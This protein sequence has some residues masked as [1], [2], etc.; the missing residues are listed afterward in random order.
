[1][2]KN[3]LFNL[4]EAENQLE[5]SN[6]GC[7]NVVY[8]KV[9]PTRLCTG[10]LFPNGSISFKFNVNGITWLNLSKS[11]FSMKTKLTKANGAQLV[12]ADNV[13]YSMNCAQNLFSSIELRCNS[14]T[15]EKV[16]DR[17]GETSTLQHREQRSQA[18]LNTIGQSN[19]WYPD[20]NDRIQLV[21]SDGTVAGTGFV[22]GGGSVDAENYAMISGLTETYSNVVSDYSSFS[23][24]SL[25]TSVLPVVLTPFATATASGLVINHTCNAEIFFEGIDNGS[26]TATVNTTSMTIISTVGPSPGVQRNIG[27]DGLAGGVNVQTVFVPE[28][29]VGGQG[30]YFSMRW[31]GRVTAGDQIIM[32][33]STSTAVTPIVNNFRLVVTELN[34]STGATSV[35]TDDPSRRIT[36][37][38]LTFQPPL[39]AFHMPHALPAGDYELVCVPYNNYQKR[40]VESL[41]ADKVVGTDYDFQVSDF[42]FYA[43]TLDGP[44]VSDKTY[45]LDLNP[46]AVQAQLVDNNTA[47]QQKFF[48]V[49]PSTYAVSVFFQSKDAGTNT[50]FSPS[51]FS[52]LNQTERTLSKLAV[53]YAGITVPNTGSFLPSYAQLSN[54]YRGEL[55]RFTQLNSGASFDP[56]GGEDPN[57]WGNVNGMYVYLPFNKDQTDMSTRLAISYQFASAPANTNIL[58]CAHYKRTARI[59]VQDSKVIDVRTEDK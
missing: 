41:V 34:A 54:D 18:W 11:F 28:N 30:K 2:S 50:L 33:R 23:A 12:S 5:S 8:R 3:S 21:S 39:S 4:L 31:V 32:T 51:K 16:E 15:I 35:T 52:T 26:V 14:K 27:Q 1:M 38:Q 56:A 44:R 43:N 17:V 59:V 57:L 53:T 13:G 45:L 22:S 48:D 37:D 55:L 10:S 46:L 40:A 29:D 19:M 49:P 47:L 25:R 9:N 36:G 58:I 20:V 24:L 6:Q 7:S 42:V